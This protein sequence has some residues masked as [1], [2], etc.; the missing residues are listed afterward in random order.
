M[1]PHMTWSQ[2]QAL[3]GTCTRYR[4]LRGKC[5]TS[6]GAAPAVA[7]QNKFSLNMVFSRC[8]ALDAALDHHKAQVGAGRAAR[9]NHLISTTSATLLPASFTVG[10][11]RFTDGYARCW[12]TTTF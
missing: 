2:L 8:Y 10:L 3:W 11:W 5:N 4:R 12:P 9:F 6:G 1:T 7:L